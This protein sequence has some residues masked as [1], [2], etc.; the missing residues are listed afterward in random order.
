MTPILMMMLKKK[1]IAL[2]LNL[3][4]ALPLMNNQMWKGNH[5]ER[6]SFSQLK[7]TMALFI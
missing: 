1:A 4:N 2:P 3:A 6:R 5:E 7:L